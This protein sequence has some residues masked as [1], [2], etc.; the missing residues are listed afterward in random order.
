VTAA[1]DTITVL[2]SHARRLAKTVHPDGAI[3][4]YDLAKTFD[5]IEVPLAGFADLERLLR[6]LADRRDCA[7]VRGAIVDP[8]RTKRVQRLLRDD[9]PTL[10]DVPRRWIALDIDSLPRPA[11]IAPEDLLGCA[12]VALHALPSE[13]RQ[14]RL[15]VQATGSHGLKPRIRIR[16]WGWVNR[17]TSGSELKYWLRTAPIDHKVFG[18][19]Q[20]IYTAPP[21]FLPGAFDP[22]ATRIAVVPGDTQILVPHPVHLR[23]PP[24]RR[25]NLR[26]PKRNDISGLI[27][28][29]AVAPA[30]NRNAMLY[31][32]ACRLAET[33]DADRDWGR[34]LLEDA[35]VQAGLSAVDAA[36][37]V[38]SA[39]RH[40][41]E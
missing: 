22:L 16:L 28:A 3:D 33:A 27:R 35:A 37:T 31:W 11:W 17:P 20:I 21:V 14:A 34:D 8:A 39:L 29:V 1:V 41:G 18:A 36:A 24:R 19:A 15:L 6:R 32:A 13:F 12:C 25:F 5:L 26:E 38:R 4:Q 9:N 23:P 2:R 40:G 7:V 30:G 10:R